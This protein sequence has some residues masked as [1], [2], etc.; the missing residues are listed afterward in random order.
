MSH[1]FSTLLAALL[2]FGVSPWASAQ[3]ST[4]SPTPQPSPAASA[5]PAAPASP[6]PEAQVKAGADILVDTDDDL[7]MDDMDEVG[8]DLADEAVKGALE[9]QGQAMRE[10]QRALAAVDKDRSKIERE[11]M[12]AAKKSMSSAEI[13]KIEKQAMVAARAAMSSAEAKAAMSLAERE[14]LESVRESQQTERERAREAARAKR[15]AEREAAEAR[16]ERDHERAEADRERAQEKGEQID[17]LYDE[18]MSAID[19]EEWGDALRSLGHLIRIKARVDAALYWTSYAKAKL[20]D[21]NGALVTLAQLQKDFPASRWVRESKALE[22]EVRGKSGQAPKPDQEDDIDLKLM[23]VSALSQSDPEEAMPLLAKLMASPTAS[24][25]V[26]ERS[27]FVLAQMGADRAGATLTEVAKGNASPDLQRKA[28]EYLGVFGGPANRKVLSEIYG[29]ATDFAIR[30]QI[31]NSFMVSGD[32]TRVLS[33]AKTE[34]DPALRSEAVKLL[35]VMQGTSELSQMYQTAATAKEKKDI[36]QALF[37]GGAVEPVLAAAKG[38]KDKE[39]RLAA[40]NNLGL[41]GRKSAGVLGDLYQVETDKE[42]K[43]QI[44]NALFLQNNPMKL[45]EIARAEKD[46]ELKKT[47]VHWLSLMNSKESRAYMMEL[48]KD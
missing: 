40:I 32:R 47:A 26:R 9:A 25:R 35:G 44:L 3:S 16:H 6:A 1:R 24:R 43:S 31:L 12:R 19:E 42:C 23:A 4:A 2:L 7:D 36:L 17:E 27:L 20:G 8:A 30:R 29:T 14:A 5:S 37:I 46:P 13:K 15:D 28:I 45:V 18:A 33:A 39:V 41:M 34:K 11:A 38:E 22:M 48:L 21:R 10:V